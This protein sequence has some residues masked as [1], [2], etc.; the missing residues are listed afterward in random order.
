MLESE[1]QASLIKRLKRIFP[2][3]IVI[4]NDSSLF[5]GI[6]DLT[7]MHGRHWAMLEVKAGANAR[8]QPNQEYYVDQWDKLSFAA[9]IYPE[10]E[11]EVIDALRQALTPCR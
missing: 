8:L 9:F 6:P 11:A 3:C 4:K 10:N 5:Q 1:Y 2:G 7:I